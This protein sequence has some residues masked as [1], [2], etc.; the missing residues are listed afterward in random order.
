M[1]SIW[2]Y[3]ILFLGDSLRRSTCFLFSL[4]KVFVSRCLRPPLLLLLLLLPV[5]LL[6]LLPLLLSRLVF[7]A[8]AIECDA[9]ALLVDTLEAYCTIIKK[10][11]QRFLRIPRLP[12]Y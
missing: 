6:L 12:S 5:L 8:L 7:L 2:L 11:E 4:G 10:S 3:Y 1:L 9:R